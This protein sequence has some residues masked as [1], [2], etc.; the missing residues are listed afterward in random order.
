MCSLQRSHGVPSM[1]VERQQTLTAVYVSLLQESSCSQHK[2][3][4]G[5]LS[6]LRAAIQLLRGCLRRAV[7]LGVCLGQQGQHMVTT[8]Q[9]VLRSLAM[10][11]SVCWRS[12]NVID[13]ECW[14][15]YFT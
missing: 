15:S 9:E 8:A 1:I 4:D 6:F 7:D 3:E 13:S 5:L 2:E 11:D 10:V 12:L 14:P